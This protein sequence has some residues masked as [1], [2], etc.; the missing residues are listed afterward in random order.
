[1]P[2]QF[3]SIIHK[4][5]LNKLGEKMRTKNETWISKIWDMYVKEAERRER[6]R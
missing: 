5:F 2:F 4:G 6:E 3:L 1:M